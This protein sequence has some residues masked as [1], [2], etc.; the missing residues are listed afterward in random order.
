MGRYVFTLTMFVISFYVFV[1]E[2]GEATVYEMCG[3]LKIQHLMIFA[4]KKCIFLLD[5]MFKLN[6][7]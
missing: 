5:V 1:K 4:I 7:I 3:I 6:I 2:Y